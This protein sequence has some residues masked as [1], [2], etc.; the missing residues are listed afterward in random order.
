MIVSEFK[1]NNEYLSQIN[2]Q[3]V[4]PLVRQPADFSPFEGGLLK[5]SILY[6]TQVK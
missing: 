2:A 3:R 6:R 5:P 4:I 1:P